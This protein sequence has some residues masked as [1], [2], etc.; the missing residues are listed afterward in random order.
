MAPNSPLL[1]R[2]GFNPELSVKA[3]S[4]ASGGRMPVPN[5]PRNR[6]LSATRN[7]AAI[8]GFTELTVSSGKSGRG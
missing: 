2:S 6:V 4:N 5:D 7:D 8:L 3:I 1:L